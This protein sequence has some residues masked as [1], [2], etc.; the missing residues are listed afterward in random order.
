MNKPS[1]AF[2]KSRKID[3]AADGKPIVVIP[4]RPALELAIIVSAKRGRERRRAISLKVIGIQPFISNK[5]E[6][7]PVEF[8]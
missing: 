3:R 7:T 5:L 2:L 1:A 4:K 6:S 8:I